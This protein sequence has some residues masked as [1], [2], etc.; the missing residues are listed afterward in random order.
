MEN[1]STNTQPKII[2][3]G[4]NESQNKSF[5]LKRKKRKLAAIKGW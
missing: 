5:N 2:N 1:Q 4:S 3:T